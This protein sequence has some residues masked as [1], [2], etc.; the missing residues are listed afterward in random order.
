MQGTD[1]GVYSVVNAQDEI[2]LFTGSITTELRVISEG[3]HSCEVIR[4]RD[5]LLG[6]G[7]IHSPLEL[8]L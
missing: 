5:R 1:D 4:P 6:G 3:Q 7:G 2:V 8:R